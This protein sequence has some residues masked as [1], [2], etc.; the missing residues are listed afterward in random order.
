MAKGYI[1]LH[2]QMASWEWYKHGDTA[3]V[4]IHLLI[5]AERFGRKV[6]GTEIKPGQVVITEREIAEELGYK[7]P[8]QRQTIRTA[9]NRL[10]STNEITIQSTNQKT[11]ITIEN[12]TKY[13]GAENQNNQE[14]NQRINQRVTNKKPTSNQRVTNLPIIRE[15]KESREIID[16]Y[17]N[18]ENEILSQEE[19]ESRLA[20]MR[21]RIKQVSARFV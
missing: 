11:V 16:N 15:S 10:K 6:G 20:E 18:G 21:K 14:K 3:R 19:T 17:K 8:N 5:R 7:W 13:Q 12:Y 1:K 2:R 9:L 4:F